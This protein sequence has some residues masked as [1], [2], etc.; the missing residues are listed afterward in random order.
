MT[1]PLT[2]LI[3]RLDEA[4]AW[5][6]VHPPAHPATRAV[7]EALGGMRA[8]IDAGFGPTAI[9]A[10]GTWLTWTAI[11]TETLAAGL[12][13]EDDELADLV[14]EIGRLWRKLP[15]GISLGRKRRRG[16][17]PAPVFVIAGAR[18]VRSVPLVDGGMDVLAFDWSTGYLVRDMSQLAAVV[19]P[20]GG[21]VDVVDVVTFYEAV[22]AL[23]HQHG[24]PAPAVPTP[25]SALGTAVD[26]L[27]TGTATRPYR[28]TVNGDE[29]V[30][31]VNDWPDEPTTYRLE[32]NGHEAFGFD[33]WPDNWS[34]P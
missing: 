34:R 25:E 16:P 21:D 23:R 10:A 32:I 18:P 9:E 33:G 7:A 26:W 12:P 28:A 27:P 3:A 31:L 15:P 13:G 6:E 14:R 8:V 17:S 1:Y 4:F 5:L 20:A 11:G 19:A 22:S 30:V 2:T 24:L 29:W